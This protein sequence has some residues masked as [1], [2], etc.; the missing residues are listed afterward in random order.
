MGNE[1]IETGSSVMTTV[2]DI[3]DNVHL[4]ASTPEE[5]QAA[6]GSLAEW[7]R[8]KVSIVKDEARD[9]TDCCIAATNAGWKTGPFERRERIAEGRLKFY[10]K[11]LAAVDAGYVIVPNF[12]VDVFAIRTAKRK[13][14][15]AESD[16]RWSQ[17]EQQAQT[18]PVGQGRYVDPLPK[19]FQRTRHETD[20]KTGLVNPKTYYYPKEFDEIEFPISVAKPMVM[21]ATHR[22]M[23]TK[24]F[25]EIGCLP[26]RRTKGDPIVT[27][28]VMFREGASEKRLTFLIA[29]WVDTRDL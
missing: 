21:K 28:A 18:L 5:M 1:L 9:A 20:K 13:P 4:V 23:A 11:C 29:W 19:V 3:T 2:D 6:Q 17:F 16:S 7:F 25:D 24:I 26:N 14:K 22:A 10:E 27:G 15:E 8:Q 12:P